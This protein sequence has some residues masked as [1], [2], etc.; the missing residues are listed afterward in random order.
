MWIYI[1]TLAALASAAFVGSKWVKMRRLAQIRATAQAVRVDAAQAHLEHAQ[2]LAHVEQAKT[3]INRAS[4]EDAAALVDDV[5]GEE[6]D[7]I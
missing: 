5:F 4:A 2:A 3:E 6:G 1:L 7:P